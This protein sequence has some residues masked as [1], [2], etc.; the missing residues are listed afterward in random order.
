MKENDFPTLFLA[1]S[2]TLLAWS[3][4]RGDKQSIA[5]QT[6]GP[7]HLK[8]PPLYRTLGLPG[9]SE[10]ESLVLLPGFIDQLP[11]VYNSLFAK[12]VLLMELA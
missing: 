9:D 10:R 3:S 2:A 8:S 1:L 12:K 11:Q 4:K 6:P 5:I 7:G